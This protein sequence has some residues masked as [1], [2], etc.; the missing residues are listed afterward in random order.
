M[1]RVICW[2]LIWERAS[3]SMARP[4]SPVC[5]VVFLLMEA[6]QPVYGPAVY[7][8]VCCSVPVDG[9]SPSMARPSTPAC[10]VVFLLM[11]AARLRP[12]RLPQ[13]VL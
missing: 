2:A 3:P 6:G 12:S 1:L 5:V 8:S 7:P 4:S 10:V 11:G 9:S 13:C